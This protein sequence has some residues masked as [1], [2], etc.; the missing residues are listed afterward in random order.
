MNSHD[1][2]QEYRHRLQKHLVM[3]R[4]RRLDF[5]DGITQELQEYRDCHLLCTYEELVNAFGEP[6]QV[7]RQFIEQSGSGELVRLTKKRRLLWRTALGA[8]SVLAI[9]LITWVVILLNHTEV[10]V[11][12][13]ITELH[14]KSVYV[15]VEKEC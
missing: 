5:L 2:V 12:E 3:P 8:L 11:E 7:A 10:V 4:L 13:E 1:P 9:C 14:R 6:E 15:N